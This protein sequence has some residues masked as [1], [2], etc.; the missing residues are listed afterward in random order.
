MDGIKLVKLVLNYLDELSVSNAYGSY[1]KIYENLDLAAA[2]FLRETGSL[3]KEASITTLAD[4]QTYDLPPDYIRPYMKT[5]NGC[6]FG[7]YY[8]ATEDQ[9]TWPVMVD[10]STIF[11]AN[12]TDSQATP[13]SFAIID[14]SDKGSLIQSTITAAGEKDAGQVTLTDD[15]KLFLSTDKVYERDIVHNTDDGEAGSTGYVLDVT[16]DT[17]LEV[18]L[19]GGD[20]DMFSEND[21]YVIQPASV[22]QLTFNAPVEIAGDTFTLPYVCMP[23]PVYSDYGFWRFNSRVCKGIAYGAASLF[24]VPMKDYVGS[25]EIGG[26]FA[27]EIRKARQEIA[28]NTLKN[29]RRTR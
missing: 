7:R 26:L 10:Y 19:F 2:I 12:L 16:D 6:W 21:N 17:N 20:D 9:T 4:T 22:Q 25:D 5:P 1:L 8:N 28:Q 14:K 15:T 29:S 27:A 23:S 18:A 13:N 11:I 3:H 24:Q